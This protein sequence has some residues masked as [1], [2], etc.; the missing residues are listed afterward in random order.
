MKYI[1]SSPMRV[2]LCLGILALVGVYSGLQLP[3]SL[4]PN[5]SK[6][7]VWVS[8]SYGTSTSDEFV[9][10]HGDNI[11]RQIQ[12]VSIDGK[13]VEKLGSEYG[14]FNVGYKVEFEWGTPANSA[15]DE[16]KLVMN[17][18]SSRF[19]REVRDSLRVRSWSN[20]AGFLALSYYSPERSLDELYDILEPALM[21]KLG[22]IN[23]ADGVHLYNPSKKEVSLEIIPETLAAYQLFP[24]D[25]EKAVRAALVGR[26]GGSIQIGPSNLQI[27]IPKQ[28]NSIEALSKILIPTPSGQRVHLSDV[29]KLDVGPEKNARRVF[30]TSGMASLILF[31]DPKPGANV[32]RMAEEILAIVKEVAP[33]LPKDIQYKNLV[34]PSEFIRNAVSNVSHEVILGAFLAVLVL[35]FFIGSFRNVGTAAIEI[36]LSMILAFILMRMTGMNLNI[37]SLGGLALSAGMNVDASIVVMENI[38]RHFEENKRPKTFEGRLALVL[39]AVNEVKLPVVASTI[40][41]LVVFIPLAFTS[42]LTD[43]ILG[44]LAKTVVFSHG[45]SAIVALILV[46]TVRLQLLSREKDAKP[47]RSP[48]ERQIKFVETNYAKYLKIFINRPKVM[49]STCLG[50]VL[51]LGLLITVVLPKLPK[52]IIG[53]PDTDWVIL[54]VRTKGNSL[55]QQME[56]IAEEKEAELL[57]KFGDKIKYTF[58]QIRGANKA[59][60]MAR[61]KD[62]G[63]M[64]FVWKGLEKEFPN[65]PFTRFFV[66]PWNPAELPIP[67]PPHLRIVIRGGTLK[68]RAARTKEIKE[69]VMR[70][71]V[72]PRVWTDPDTGHKEAVVF[73]PFHEQWAL[74]EQQGNYFGL[75]DIADLARVATGG[76]SVGEIVLNDQNM[77][78]RLS[79]PADRVKTP[80]DLGA[81]PIG[82]KEK[83]IP[84]KALGNIS[85]R[86]MDPQVFREDGRSLFVISGKHNKGDHHKAPAS[87]AK[88]AEL[89]KV[90]KAKKM[91]SPEGLKG[92]SV[93]MEDPA[94]DM[95]EAIEQLIWAISLSILLI[96]LVMIFQFGSIVNSLIVLVA[97][98]LGIIGVIASLFVFGG[99]LSLNSALGVILLNGIAVANSIILVDFMKKLV[100][101][102]MVPREAAVVAARKRL[103]PILITSLT[104]LLGMMPIALGFGEGGKILQP[105]GIAVSGGLWFSMAMTL[106]IV[107]AL[108]VYYLE[109]VAS[110]KNKFATAGAVERVP[111]PGTTGLPE[112]SPF[113]SKGWKD[114]KNSKSDQSRDSLL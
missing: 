39:K 86:K 56:S 11:E 111:I 21:S 94:K 107:P 92:P 64:D 29:T 108:Q 58:V 5:S 52:E 20:N 16:V 82:V 40:A 46:P 41:S 71:Q 13:K 68:E 33:S 101:R 37:I 96:F 61:L 98:P 60:L 10:T 12:G 78:V 55:M 14:R 50:L 32:K 105:L 113:F 72:F 18:Y 49:A 84:L 76:R 67:N 109:Y 35:Y 51:V 59:T 44:D 1:Y 79:Y 27:Q 22:K 104:T 114:A 43:A 77:N 70:D 110:R 106:F 24:R 69:L 42:A 28:A 34:D 74:L 90:W 53:T 4:F 99:T 48:M 102:G 9:K 45:F 103:R 25:I 2:Y 100:D 3:V 93:Y 112:Q 54:G 75:G 26:N 80:E 31:A 81:I 88:V 95:N 30:K 65:T 85:I 62:K 7:T 57:A 8:I 89:L 19:S 66:V 63:D 83:L 15:L 91:A 87:Q 23:D 36:P 6:P 47:M 38:F 73:E 17:S 97:V